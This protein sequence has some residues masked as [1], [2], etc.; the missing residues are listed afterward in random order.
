MISI[1]NIETIVNSF[2][3][4]D[5]LHI[6]EEVNYT[7]DLLIFLKE[8]KILIRYIDLLENNDVKVDGYLKKLYNKEVDRIKDNSDMIKRIA[9]SLK[10]YEKDFIFFMNFQH[11]PDMGEDIDILILK[12]FKDIKNI[13]LKEFPLIEKKPSIF[14]KL[15][16]KIMFLHSD[17]G[18]E[19]ELHNARLGRLGEFLV[20]EKEID[21]CKKNT[22]MI[23]LPS[24]EL[25]LI[26]NVIQRLYTRSHLRISEILF[27]KL[28]MGKNFDWEI[29]DEIARKFGVIRGLNLY[30]KIIDSLFLRETSGESKFAYNNANKFVYLKNSLFYVSISQVAPLF[31]M[32]QFRL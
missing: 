8:N 10:N 15:A 32:R 27:L 26:I 6:S 21:Y 11:Y 12:N 22:D 1:N 7:K 17:N 2:F 29:V 19:I 4:P 9:F 24:R 23:H 13:L 5:I 3:Q 20:T 14:N 25:Q 18:L 28:N 31:L 16:K 30:L